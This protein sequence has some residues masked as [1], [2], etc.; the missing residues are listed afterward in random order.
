[1]KLSN[2]DLIVLG[3]IVFIATALSVTIHIVRAYGESAN[4][5]VDFA[6]LFT[7]MWSFYRVGR[8]HNGG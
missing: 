5:V 3:I 6:V 7:L 1:M 4:A 2:R 8:S